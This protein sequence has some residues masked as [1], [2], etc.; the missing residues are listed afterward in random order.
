M[1]LIH[2][3]EVKFLKKILKEGYIKSN[4]L[5]NNLGHGDGIYTGKNK[6]VY[7]NII[8]KINSEYQIPSPSTSVILYFDYEILYNRSFYISNMLSSKPHLL[9]KWKT[10]SG[11][12]YKLKYPRYQDLK[13]TKRILKKFFKYSVNIVPNGFGFTG[14]QQVAIL[15]QTNLKYLKAIKINKISVRD[16]KI[17]NSI[18]EKQKLDVTIIS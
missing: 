18:I 10:D 12:K 3:T 8:D 15:N 14:F 9:G 2:E 6:Y 1:Y 7:F 11:Y 17:I 16:L 4:N 13:E 5:T